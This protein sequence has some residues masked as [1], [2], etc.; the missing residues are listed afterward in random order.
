MR[1]Q[2]QVLNDVHVWAY[3]I[4][5]MPKHMAHNQWGAGRR[6][7]VL[8]YELTPFL[9]TTLARQTLYREGHLQRVMCT[10][11]EA[12][13][14][15]CFMELRRL[16]TVRAVFSALD[17]R[18][19]IC[20]HCGGGAAPSPHTP[21]RS[22]SLLVPIVHFDSLQSLLLITVLVRSLFLITTLYRH[23]F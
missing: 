10:V 21:S 5:R 4:V 22:F 6:W 12:D 2:E 13:V 15:L 20:V 19:T 7:M 18:C 11:L 17:D 8:I 9:I 3:G 23:I 16:G 14:L 1:W